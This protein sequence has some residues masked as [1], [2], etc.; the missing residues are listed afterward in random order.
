MTLNPTKTKIVCT[1]GPACTS[2]AVLE[3]MVR[4]GMDVVRLNFSHG[5]HDEHRAL[6]K[7]VRSV[8][9]KLQKPVA[10]LQDLQGPKIR[11]GELPKNGIPFTEGSTVVFTTATPKNKEIPVQYK[12]LHKDVEP[13][14]HLLLDDGLLECVVTKVKGHTITA[15]VVVGGTLKSHKGINVP[16]NSISAPALSE[17]DKEDLLFGLT[18]KVDFVALS[19]VKNAADLMAVK[20][21]IAEKRHIGTEVIAK[22]ERHEAVN[23]LEAIVKAADGVMVARGDLGVE[24]PAEQVPIIQREIVRMGR[25]YGKPVIIA[26]QMLQS[27]QENPRPTRAEISDA[28]TTVFEHADAFMLSNET[29]VGKY[30]VE[31]VKTLT[32]VAAAVEE[33]LRKNH[34]HLLIPQKKID[35]PITNATCLE[36]AR[37]AETLQAAA[38]IIYTKSGYTAREIAKYRPETPLIVVTPNAHTQRTLNLVWG[39]NDT[40]LSTHTH[41]DDAAVIALL[42]KQKR[43]RHGDDVVF[44]HTSYAKSVLKTVRV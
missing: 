17:K 14:D 2:E 7:N 42:L 39:V 44:C 10:I 15:T 38:I 34:Q 29:S 24:M 43:I 6:I 36:A 35:L 26:T 12:N 25:M 20:K 11:V 30:P 31:A 22:I 37:M 23:D 3:K 13:K 18:Q 9:A 16:T 1:L 27:M 40:I 32:R 28:A 33:E 41:A 21:I 8:A 4:A 5:T 19:F